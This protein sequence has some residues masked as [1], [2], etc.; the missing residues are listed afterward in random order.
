M[1]IL[2]R[3]DVFGSVTMLNEELFLSPILFLNQVILGSPCKEGIFSNVQV[4]DTE[5]FLYAVGFELVRFAPV[6]VVDV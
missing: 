5:S 3:L 2:D 6:K 4:R 1:R